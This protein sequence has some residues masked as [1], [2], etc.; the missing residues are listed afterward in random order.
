MIN[1]A[2]DWFTIA[3]IPNKKAAKIADITNKTWCTRYPLQQKIVF[4]SC[5][6]FI[7]EF[8]KMC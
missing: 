3:Q 1:P 4:D 7:A 6:G 8:S 5:T 2:T